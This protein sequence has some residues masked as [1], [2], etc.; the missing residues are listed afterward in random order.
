MPADRSGARKDSPCLQG[1]GLE[2][3]H[4]CTAQVKPL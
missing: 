1:R 3:L 4:L 2:Q